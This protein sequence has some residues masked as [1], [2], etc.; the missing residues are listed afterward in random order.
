MEKDKLKLAITELAKEYGK[1]DQSILNILHLVDSVDVSQRLFDL[2]FIILTPDSIYKQKTKDIVEY[3]CEKTGCKIIAAKL[4]YLDDFYIEE[5]YKY[6][7]QKKIMNNEQTF[8]WLMRKSFQNTP[9]L[10]LILQS[11]HYSKDYFCETLLEMKGSYAIASD[12]KGETIRDRFDALSRILAV[13]HSSDDILCLLREASLFFSEK[14]LKELLSM[15]AYKGVD[16][17]TIHDLVMVSSEDNIMDTMLKRLQA[18]LTLT[19]SKNYY[20]KMAEQ[21]LTRSKESDIPLTDYGHVIRKANI[22]LSEWDE[23]YLLNSIF[24]EK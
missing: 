5:L 3:I 10:A 24:F 20:L 19:K 17:E 21:I 8:W 12:Y 2:A 11:D 1:K 16:L 15:C 4:K 14:E 7:F 13:M 23:N 9:C 6:T 22:Y 18:T